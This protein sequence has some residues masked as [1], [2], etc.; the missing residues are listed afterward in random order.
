MERESDEISD[1]EREGQRGEKSRVS[2]LGRVWGLAW[3]CWRCGKKYLWFV[4]G[5]Y[6][7]FSLF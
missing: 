5:K 1:G 7:N 3:K 2:L 4:E 6:V